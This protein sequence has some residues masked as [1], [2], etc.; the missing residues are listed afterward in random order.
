VQLICPCCHTRFPLDAANQDEAAR[1]LLA[2]RGQLPPRVW[3]PFIAYLGLFRSETRA[4][5]WDRALR[6]AREV[7]ELKADP[8]RLETALAETVEALRLKGG[9]PLKNHNYLKR[10]LET[11]ACSPAVVPSRSRAAE[12]TGGAPAGKRM[13]ALNALAE[14]AGDDW[15]R[16]EI[17]AGLQALVAQ[18]LKG[19]PA[20]EMITL[21]ADVWHVALRKTL[22]IAEVDS[23]RIRRGF[24]RLFPTVSEWP[25]P[26]QLL[27]LM[28][29][30]PPRVSLPEPEMTDEKF[31]KGLQAA[32]KLS[33]TYRK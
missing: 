22:T 4:L 7:M 11:A 1:D 29:D 17:C 13:A 24:E 16:L 30:R 10:V 8:E 33:E 27:A 31:E 32:R 15:L 9:P 3:G 19:Q 18:S 12:T 5:A 26:K 14:W 20:A 25:A 23:S 28:P 6:L 2:L 21:N